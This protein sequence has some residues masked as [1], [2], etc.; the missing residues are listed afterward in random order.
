MGPFGRGRRALSLSGTTKALRRMQRQIL[1]LQHPLLKDPFLYSQPPSCP[2]T[3]TV[4]HYARGHAAVGRRPPSSPSRNVL[5]AVGTG[6]SHT[7]L[8]CLLSAFP[9]R[10]R[11]QGSG[12][13]GMAELSPPR[14]QGCES[15]PARPPNQALLPCFSRH[16]KVA[17]QVCAPM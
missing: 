16:G 7:A 1:G 14:K 10:R 4:S 11:F 12:R 15:K 2:L 17:V 5:H 13:S 9:Q 8:V 3:R 6:Q